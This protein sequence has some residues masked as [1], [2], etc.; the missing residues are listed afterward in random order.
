[1]NEEITIALHA[2][3]EA[4]REMHNEAST[5]NLHLRTNIILLKR[6]NQ[7]LINQLQEKE[8]TIEELKK[9]AITGEQN[10]VDQIIQ[11]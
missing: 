7:L 9:P 10:A 11:Q 4:Q 6:Q 1:M 3:L 8:K 2:Q 5:S